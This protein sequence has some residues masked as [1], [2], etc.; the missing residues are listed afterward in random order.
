MA[1]SL[2]QTV[3]LGSLVFLIAALYSSVGHGG[4]SGYL[5]GLALFGV[6]PAQMATTALILNVLVAGIA[7]ISYIRAGHFSSR[8]F[9]PL[10]I[11]SIPLAFA[12]GLLKVSDPLYYLLLAIALLFAAIRLSLSLASVKTIEEV[13]QMPLAV[14]LPVG[15]G[16]GLLSGIVGVGGGI[17]LS[18]IM[19]LLK[20]ATA[21]QTAATAAVFIVV[22]SLAGLGGRALRHDLSL[23][24]AIPLL[25]AAFAGGLLGS[26]W[27][28]ERLSSLSLRRVLALV[29]AFA[30]TKLIFRAY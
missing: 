17:F 6:P 20:W 1:F 16:I 8:L 24:P 13:R 22:N 10:A 4:A 15:G 14:S 18:P 9:W 29:L 25:A 12:G 21:K 5:A 26:S 3:A 23:L 27:G 7:S 28:A 2:A 11:V 19:L 30:A